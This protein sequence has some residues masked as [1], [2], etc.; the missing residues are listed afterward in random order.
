MNASEIRE[1]YPYCLVS[2]GN[3]PMFYF[4]SLP[5]FERWGK[6]SGKNHST[7]GLHPLFVV[8]TEG[9]NAKILRKRPP[10]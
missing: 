9:I 4:A 6:P 5:V 7:K 8:K 1:K 3:I 2:E 10:K